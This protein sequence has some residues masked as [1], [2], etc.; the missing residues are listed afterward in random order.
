MNSNNKRE[1]NL[2]TPL[3][4]NKR[5][6]L[7]SN[8][9]TP[10]KK[11]AV[12]QETVPVPLPPWLKELQTIHFRLN[13]YFTFL[14]SRKH[15]IPKFDTLKQPVEKT[16]NRELTHLDV[17]KLVALLPN[18]LVF[19]Y[20]NEEQ[21]HTEKKEFNFMQGG[22]KQ[23]DLDMFKLKDLEYSQQILV[24]EFV[25]GDLTKSK[26][27]G[28][29]GIEM[30]T[31]TPESMKKKIDKRNAK[32][33]R[34]AQEYLELCEAEG[35]QNPEDRLTQLANQRLPRT[36]DF[37]DPIEQMKKRKPLDPNEERPAIPEVIE[38]IKTTVY[39]DQIEGSFILPQRLAKYEELKFELSQSLVSALN[40]NGFYKHQ[41]EALNAIHAGENVI[42]T[43]STSS[44]KSL[45]YQIPVLQNL[46]SSETNTAMYIFPTKALAQDQKRSFHSI[47]SKLDVKSMVETYDG[48]TEPDERRA[49]RNNA[50]VIFTNPDTVHSS[51]LPNHQGWRHFLLKLKYVVI[52]ELHIYKGLFGS[53]VAL[54]MRRLRRVCSF[55]G[56]DNLQ[57]ISCSATLGD[58]MKHMKLVFGVH[59]VTHISEDGSPSGEK[60]LVV[61]NPPHIN[62]R[63]LS[64]G[65]VNFITESAR[66]LV[67]LVMNNVRT[68]AFCYVRRVCE[69][70]MKEV[71]NRFEEIGHP[72]LVSQVMS[73]RGGYSAS[74]RR[75]IER[76]MFH[77]NLQAVISTN[78]LELG[79]DIGGLDAVIMCGF[80]LSLA[81][82]HQQ[83]GRA[84]RR[85]KD[86]LTVVVGADS[87]VDQHY[88][89]HPD[90][91]LK[92]EFQELVLDFEN[93]L[94]LEGHL[95]CAAFEIPIV[96]D[97]DSYYFPNL[98]KVLQLGKLERDT[99]GYHTTNR[100][101]PWPSAHVSIRGIEE[102]QYAVVDIT[103]DRNIVIEEIEASRTS[104]T[105]Y[106]GGIFIHQGYPYL[107]REFNV[108]D[109]YAKVER[110]D[111]DWVTSQRDFTDVD[112]IEIELVRSLEDSDTP[113]YYGKIKTTVTVFGFFKLDK[114][115]KIIDAVEVHNPPV[116][117]DSKGFWID[118]PTKA[119]TIIADKNLNA[120][121]GIHAAQ[122]AIMGILPLVITT[123]TDEIQTECKAP[124]KEFAERQTTRKRPARLIFHDAKGG[125]YGSGL[126]IKAFENC[127][128]VL[129]DAVLRIE[130]CPCDWGCPDCVAASFCKESS[131][132]LSKPAALVIL[133]CVLGS[134]N[135]V[136]DKIKN[137]P[138]G[139]LPDIQIETITPVGLHVKFAQDVKILD[140]KEIRDGELL[141][142]PKNENAGNLEI[143]DK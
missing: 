48:D 53:H 110:V 120:A 111:V 112:P 15:V 36:K 79:I 87:P 116:T 32:F 103:N 89:K 19:K 23:K 37:V 94:I 51:I 77:G 117:I 29:T 71:R 17:C 3:Q 105:L 16:I 58:P 49:I 104:F 133:H 96:P 44:G 122:H 131:L 52:D 28:G 93:I 126:S 70:L 81:N 33:I 139:N 4:V 143:P 74:D 41:A 90:L 39:K 135:D 84:G 61:W 35:F 2:S 10:A 73:Y 13:T 5:P 115:K 22:H 101:L 85:N 98:D 7:P 88:M 134:N 45:I 25:D 106:E 102:D 97:I 72:E 62:P 137:G 129:R 43:T 99:D 138:E 125:K 63:D 66:I 108:E 113:V 124:E 128:S 121:G 24:L 142:E 92:M 67:E 56:N 18:D 34:A 76:E 132:V 140:V 80:P 20:I 9:T 6:K 59:Q 118:I 54:I 47:M 31:Y 95:Q 114:N 123:G 100:Y 21:I 55:L 82:F 141:K 27:N 130:E 68:I 64:A 14:S 107:I 12:K 8:S 46:D 65:R 30:P 11:K 83:S 60:H 86:S 119:L 40:I 38:R 57:F 109:R 1:T 136:Y 26:A 50:R 75:E 127:Q 42:I 78:A 91:L 69:L